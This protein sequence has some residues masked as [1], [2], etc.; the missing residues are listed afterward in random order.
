MIAAVRDLNRLELAGESVRA[1]L[2]ALAVAAPG[3]AAH[4]DRRRRLGAPLR[5]PDRHL[6]DADLR[7]QAAPSW[8]P[9]YGADAVTLLLENAMYAARRQ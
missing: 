6:A 8:R 5:G 3:L 9:A 4:G 1:A 7:G 2:E